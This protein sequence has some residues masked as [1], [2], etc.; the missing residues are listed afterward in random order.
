MSWTPATV[1]AAVVTIL[2]TLAAIAW[3]PSDPAWK[4]LGTIVGG[5][6]KV[7]FSVP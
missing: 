6:A 5:A 2:I 1:T 4:L 3:L 7:V